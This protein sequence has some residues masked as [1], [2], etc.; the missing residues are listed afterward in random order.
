MKKTIAALVMLAFAGVSGAALAGDP[1]Q[2][3]K[4]ET[5]AQKKNKRAEA[6]MSRPAGAP[7]SEDKAKRSNP[8]KSGER[9]KARAQ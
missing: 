1:K 7:A 4:P 6:E 3:K 2:E 8:I 5:A 9:P